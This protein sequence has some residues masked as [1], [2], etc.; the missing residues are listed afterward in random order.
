MLLI[1]AP[2]PI[3]LTD[4]FSP[5]HIEWNATFPQTLNYFE[6]MDYSIELGLREE[7]QG[8]CVPERLTTKEKPRSTLGKQSHGRSFRNG[9]LE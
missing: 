3:P 5:A 4:V 9:A 8:Y 2:F 6:D 7:L 1:D